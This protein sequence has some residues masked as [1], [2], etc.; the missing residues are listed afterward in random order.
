VINLNKRSPAST[1]PKKI[2]THRGD[3]TR[4]WRET[5]KRASAFVERVWGFAERP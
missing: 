1:T 5:E 4:E 3:E 2:I